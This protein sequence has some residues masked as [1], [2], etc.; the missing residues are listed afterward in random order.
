[1]PIVFIQEASPTTIEIYRG[2]TRSQDDLVLK[3]EISDLSL[4]DKQWK[5]TEC[6]PSRVKGEA[7][8]MERPGG[9]GS[10]GRMMITIS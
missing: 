5:V 3:A 2:D 7:F 6:A 9:P 4:K 1:M 8:E 10:A